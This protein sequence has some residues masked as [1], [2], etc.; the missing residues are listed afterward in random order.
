[1]AFIRTKSVKGHKYYQVVENYRD[2]ERNGKHRQRV[3]HHLG[4]HT[5][6]KQK[7]QSLR[8]K[9]SGANHASEKLYAEVQYWKK[10]F[11]RQFLESQEGRFEYKPFEDPVASLM[12]KA[13]SQH[14]PE[15]SWLLTEFEKIL[16]LIAK[17]TGLRPSEV[18]SRW[19]G[20]QERQREE[21]RR[22]V[23]S[24][25]EQNM[26]SREQARS[27]YLAF[28]EKYRKWEQARDAD[29]LTKEEEREGME[30]LQ[31]EWIQ[32]L[33]IPVKFHEA[34]SSATEHEERAH[35][36]RAQIN[37]LLEIQQKYF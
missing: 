36:Y 19:R 2:K 37:E 4:K 14:R 12:Q 23:M 10:E 21:Y 11:G 13:L 28:E 15:G 7:L 20:E 8:S 31:E 35:D 30:R 9:E 1:M 34:L 5:S 25:C 26:P 22:R 16:Q 17:Q 33:Y 29:H 18:E 27:K 6:V 24:A 3:I 32:E